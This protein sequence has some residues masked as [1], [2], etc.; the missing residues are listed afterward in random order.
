[1]SII[2]TS[3]IKEIVRRCI[4]IPGMPVPYLQ[5]PPGISKS[6]QIA[7]VALEENMELRDVRLSQYGALDIR[8]LPVIDKE[9]KATEWYIPDFLPRMEDVLRLQ[10]EGKKGIIIF[11]D[12]LSSA[13]PSVQVAAYQLLLDRKMGTYTIPSVEGF[14][15]FLIGA[16]NM[17]KDGAVVNPMSTALK[18]RMCHFTVE[19]DIEG[20]LHYALNNGFDYR[21]VSFLKNFPQ[22]L[23]VMPAKND[24]SIF[25]FP[26]NRSWDFV[27]NVLK[28][29][30]YDKYTYKFVEGI[31]G[32]GAALEFD[33]YVQLMSE[34]PDVEGILETGSLSGFDSRKNPSVTWGLVIALCSRVINKGEDITDKTVTNFV[35]AI[36]QLPEE[37]M[38]LGLRN[39]VNMENK[40]LMNTRIAT[41]QAWIKAIKTHLKVILGA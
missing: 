8:G 17:L 37:Y 18:N 27:S 23:H 9:R 12:E 15:I 13:T 29:S 5:G 16:G 22:H 14:T 41:N 1:M 6:A 28:A 30:V 19:N 2:K 24:P 3:E 31:V 11:L 34:M 7:Q 36:S 26:T 33:A 20:F 39:I 25:A 40:K 35:N 21:V 10:A 32:R 4:R 38:F